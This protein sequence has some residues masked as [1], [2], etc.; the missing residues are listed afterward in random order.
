MN[1]PRCNA[2]GYLFASARIGELTHLVHDTD[3]LI[4][5]KEDYLACYHCVSCGYNWANEDIPLKL[6]FSHVDL[7]QNDSYS[8]G[9]NA[10]WNDYVE[11]D[12]L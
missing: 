10:I 12:G 11:G 2:V 4:N 8:I 7:K 3:R 9:S 6:G 5:L 1:C